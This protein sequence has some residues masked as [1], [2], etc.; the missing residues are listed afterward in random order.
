[1]LPRPAS[2][3]DDLARL[4]SLVCVEPD[5]LPFEERAPKVS[6][7][8]P[9]V[10]LASGFVTEFRPV[11][12]KFHVGQSLNVNAATGHNDGLPSPKSRRSLFAIRDWNRSAVNSYSCLTASAA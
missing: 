11:R 6:R 12:V 9:D 1:M 8:S 7:V 10:K 3:R 2:H 4:R 5:N